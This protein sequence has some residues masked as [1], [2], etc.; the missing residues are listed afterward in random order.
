MTLPPFIRIAL[1]RNVRDWPI[2]TAMALT[3]ATAIAGAGA[4]W[5]FAETL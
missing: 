4:M 1:R 5:A 2:S 3:V